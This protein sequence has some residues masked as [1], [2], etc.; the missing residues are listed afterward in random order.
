MQVVGR[1]GSGVD[2]IDANAATRRGIVVVNAPE[3]N[4]IAAAEHTIGLMLALARHIPEAHALAARRQMGALD[5]HGRG[6]ARQDAGHRRPGPRRLGSRTARA[7]AGDARDRAEP[8]QTPERAA[9]MGV[10]LVDK[11]EL[12]AESDF[13]TLHAPLTAGSRNIIGAP[14]LKLVKPD[15]RIINVARGGLVAEDALLEALDAGKVAGA[16]HR[17]VRARAAA[18]GQPAAAAP[19]GHRHAAPRRL[20]R[21]GAGARGVRRGAA[22]AGRAARRAGDLRRQHAVHQR[23]DL[24]ADRALP[25]GGDA[26]GRAGDAAGIGGPAAE[27][28]NRVPGRDRRAR[29]ARCVAP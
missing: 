9:A 28:R 21:R 11:D 20:D 26:G 10:Q 14:E 7:R 4:T 15:V 25:A 24:Q 17:R 23:R 19:Q 18:D 2:N 22:G 16:A 8:F 3:G 27:R 12:L 6:A 13:I 29:V 1:A 5:V